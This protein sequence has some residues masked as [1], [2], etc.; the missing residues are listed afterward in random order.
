ML[1]ESLKGEE[2]EWFTESKK[3]SWLLLELGSKPR[4]ISLQSL[5]F[6]TTLA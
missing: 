5:H 3:M 6:K 4:A 1:F 2:T